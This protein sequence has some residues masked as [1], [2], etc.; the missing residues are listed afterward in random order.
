MSEPLMQSPLSAFNLAASAKPIDG[1][2]GVWANEIP[3]QGY[4]SLRGNA[5]DNAFIGAVSRSLDVLLPSKPCMLATSAKAKALWLSPD[6]WLIVCARHDVRA[7]LANLKASLADIRSQAVDNSGGY[8]Q[9]ALAGA[10]A[11]R[12]LSHVTVYDVPSLEAGRVVGTTFGKSSVYLHRQGDGYR[13]ILRRSFA[14]YIWRYLV[15]AAEPYGFGV[16][17]NDSAQPGAAA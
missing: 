11:S 8:T 12:V 7:L 15:R 14:D 17:R 10:D 4:I 13:L 16:A 2:A 3:L 1:S 9:I 5:G 6:E